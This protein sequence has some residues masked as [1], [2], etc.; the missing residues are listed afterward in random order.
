MKKAD[1]ALL[2]QNPR[3]WRRMRN[4]TSKHAAHERSASGRVTPFY[5]SPRYSTHPQLCPMNRLLS[6]ADSEKMDPTVKNLKKGFTASSNKFF[7][8][9]LCQIFSNIFVYRCRC[10]RYGTF[11]S[12]VAH[13]CR[14]AIIRPSNSEPN[15]GPPTPKLSHFIFTMSLRSVNTR[16]SMIRWIRTQ[17]R[18]RIDPGSRVDPKFFCQNILG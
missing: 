18:A 14:Q 4:T 13:L 1:V 9:S 15:M 6:K 17:V 7:V 16:A 2:V 12:I 3:C 5:S 8:V 11:S 10:N